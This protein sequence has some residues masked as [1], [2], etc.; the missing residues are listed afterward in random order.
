VKKRKQPTPVSRDELITELLDLARDAAECRPL[1]DVEGELREHARDLECMTDP[2]LRGKAVLGL[3]NA[4]FRAFN[5]M[6]DEEIRETY[7]AEEAALLVKLSRAIVKW[8]DMG[9]EG[10]DQE[11]RRA[12]AKIDKFLRNLIRRRKLWGGEEG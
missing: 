4:I 1:A 8:L 10:S 2:E 3:L 12:C 11:A 9:S 7:S 6:T 5:E